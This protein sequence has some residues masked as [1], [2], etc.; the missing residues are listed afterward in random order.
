MRYEKLIFLGL[1]DEIDNLEERDVKH[2][3]TD[4]LIL[5]YTFFSSH[6]YYS[7]SAGNEHKV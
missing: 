5:Y 3:L 6:H 2:L 4:F 1:D 7:A